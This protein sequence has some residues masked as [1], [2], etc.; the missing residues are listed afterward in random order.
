MVFVCLSRNLAA[1]AFNAQR[2]NAQH[3]TSHSCHHF[4]IVTADDLKF[5][6]FRVHVQ[7]DKPPLLGASSGT[8]HAN[9]VSLHWTKLN[10]KSFAWF[11]LHAR[12]SIF[13]LNACRILSLPEIYA[14]S[15]MSDAL[16]GKNRKFNIGLGSKHETFLVIQI[17]ARDWNWFAFRGHWTAPE[18]KGNQSMFHPLQKAGKS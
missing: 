14:M 11:H 2:S 17:R 1:G 18:W 5:I 9:V 7:A 12:K 10:R 13:H 8:R 3:T 6:A 16:R 15:S 4:S